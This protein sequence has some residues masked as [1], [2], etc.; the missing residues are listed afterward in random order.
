MRRK[1][2]KERGG[3]QP[4]P[5]SEA[6]RRAIEERKNT[7]KEC[8]V[9][10]RAVRVA[11]VGEEALWRRRAVGFAEKGRWP[12]FVVSQCGGAGERSDGMRCAKSD[13]LEG[14]NGVEDSTAGC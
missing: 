3:E 4:A 7:A 9:D 1:G 14:R 5:A 10:Q 2:K 12:V 13:A 8:I 11:L 6:V